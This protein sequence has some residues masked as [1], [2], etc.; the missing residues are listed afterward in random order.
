MANRQRTWRWMGRIRSAF[1][2]AICR[3]LYRIRPRNESGWSEH[4][5]AR[6]ALQHA[7]NATERRRPQRWEILDGRI[8]AHRRWSRK[9][10]RQTLSR[11]RWLAHLPVLGTEQPERQR[12]AQG[13]DGCRP[14]RRYAERLDEQV[15]RRQ[16]W[17]VS[18]GIQ[19]VCAR[20]PNLDGL[21]ASRRHRKHFRTIPRPLWRPIPGAPV[22]CLRQR[23]WRPWPH[24]GNHQHDRPR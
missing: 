10:W 17:R 13:D 2:K 11:C 5:F 20:E 22:G 1:G 18:L 15:S 9:G 16:A 19:H 3:T 23:F 7:Q 6:T 14:Q 4:H 12:H 24:V 8:F 21:P